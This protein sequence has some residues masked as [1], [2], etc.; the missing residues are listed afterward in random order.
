MT[1]GLINRMRATVSVIVFAACLL[2]FGSL[3]ATTV[4]SQG[5]SGRDES[6][7][8]PKP[9]KPT[10]TKKATP[11]RRNATQSNA[12]Q[13]APAPVMNEEESRKA[14]AKQYIANGDR[15]LKECQN[16]F[17][18]CSDK[19]IGEYRIAASLDSTNAE[20]HFKIASEIS[21][22]GRVCC[23]YTASESEYRQAANLAPANAEYH[24]QLGISLVLQSVESKY[25]E[26]ET[27][28]RLATRL[29]P[30]NADYHRW[31]A[32]ALSYQNKYREA[33]SEAREAIRLKPDE[34]DSYSTLAT[35][36]EG[37]GKFAEAENEIRMAL[38][39]ATQDYLRNSYTETLG[40]NL[41]MQ[42][43]YAEAV[44]ELN[45]VVAANPQYSSNAHFWIGRA[46]ESQNQSDR[47]EAE[48]REAI[49]LRPQF[50]SYQRALQNLLNNRAR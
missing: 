35:A 15:I 41:V 1:R 12:A 47:A 36:L 16:N 14:Q 32:T 23:D 25:V 48:Y 5:A 33:E 49:R 46:Y 19:A 3:C 7:G 20:Y 4:L 28:F 26:A 21:V 40:R 18:Q 2:L 43:R 29:A 24:Y 11:A 45:K 13:P 9:K 8:E 38:R 27:E 50:E 37:Q 22:R 34:N 10:T 6:T 30:S 31:L 39:L 17:E 44:T 42:R